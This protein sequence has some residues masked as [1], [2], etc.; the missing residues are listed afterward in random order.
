MFNKANAFQNFTSP[1]IMLSQNGKLNLSSIK[2][3]LYET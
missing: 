1:Y 2:I 3:R